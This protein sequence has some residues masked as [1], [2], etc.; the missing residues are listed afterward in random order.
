MGATASIELAKPADGSDITATNDVTAARSELHRLR[1]ALGH[2]AIANGFAAVDLEMKDVTTDDENADFN[3]CI[4][5]I[6]HIRGALRL[7]TQQTRRSTRAAV[8][9]V[10]PPLEMES[11]PDTDSSFD[12]DSEKPEGN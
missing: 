9:R 3:K 6:V 7:S 4:Q 12:S 5:E 10:I 1:K 11:G 2:L 8:P